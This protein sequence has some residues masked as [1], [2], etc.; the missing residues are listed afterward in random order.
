MGF[1]Q[2]E[3]HLA[4]WAPVWMI[5]EKLLLLWHFPTTGLFW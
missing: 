4:V 3:I 2:A 5:G 1:Q